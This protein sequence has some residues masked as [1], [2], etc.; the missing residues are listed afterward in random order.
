MPEDSVQNQQVIDSRNHLDDCGS[1]VEHD[2][3][4]ANAS[5]VDVAA[6]RPFY[7][8]AHKVLVTAGV[9][10]AIKHGANALEID[11]MAYWKIEGSPDWW[12]DHGGIKYIFPSRGDKVEVMFKYIAAKR[13]GGANI[14]FVWLDIKNPN[15][16]DPGDEKLYKSSIHYLQ[17]LARQCLLPAG[18]R[19]LYGMKNDDEIEKGAYSKLVSRGPLDPAEAIDID[20]NYDNVDDLFNRYGSKH[21]TPTRQR[22]MSKGLFDWS[23]NSW[24]ILDE[25][26]KASDSGNFG[27]IFGWTTILYTR[28]T[29][30]IRRLIT[31]VHAD[32]LIYGGVKHY[33]DGP[34]SK[35]PLDRIKKVVAETDNVHFAQASNTEWPW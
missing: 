34:M 28:D 13:R 26:K 6:S 3:D 16:C 25:F 17:D 1:P 14:V 24:N 27:R 23:L 7:A 8:I 32:G 31:E 10:A 22:I 4:N 30:N 29:R 33:Q 2:L 21:S 18:V 15:A 19:V 5:L 9:D 35:A 12:A 20:S 11:C